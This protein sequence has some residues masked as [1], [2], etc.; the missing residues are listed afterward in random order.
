[1]ITNVA[2]GV[3]VAVACKVS[4]ATGNGVDVGTNGVRVANGAAWMADNSNG[5]PSQDR[6]NI[7]VS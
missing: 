1:M 3:A 7:I 2:D 4:V 6:S 5:A